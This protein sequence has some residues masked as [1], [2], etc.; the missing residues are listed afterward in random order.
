MHNTFSEPELNNL[1]FGRAGEI[2]PFYISLLR[3]GLIFQSSL[4]TDSLLY[5][6]N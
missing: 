1:P 6:Y 4:F 5:K 2:R 3:K